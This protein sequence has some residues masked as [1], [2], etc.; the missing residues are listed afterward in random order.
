MFYMFDNSFPNTPPGK[1]AKVF[2]TISIPFHHPSSHLF[3]SLL[4]TLYFLL[5]NFYFLLITFYFLLTTNYF[6]PSTF[7]FLLSTLLQ[8]FHR[9]YG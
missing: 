8:V 7:Y 5:F 1:S 2:S 3:Y 9:G 4:F 6:L